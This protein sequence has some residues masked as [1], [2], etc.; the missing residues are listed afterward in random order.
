MTERDYTKEKTLLLEWLAE[1][2]GAASLP[3]LLSSLDDDSAPTR[4]GAVI[5]VG[6]VVGKLIEVIDGVSVRD[7][8][9][10]V[11]VAAGD[12]RD[13]LLDELASSAGEVQP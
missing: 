1:H 12:V 7:S 5:G 2:Y 11:R 13:G 6:R 8:S 3:V 10:G 4:E 9:P